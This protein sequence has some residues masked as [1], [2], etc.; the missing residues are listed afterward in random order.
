MDP[1]PQGGGRC[2]RHGEAGGDKGAGEERGREGGRA[3]GLATGGA[4]AGL[5]GERGEASRRCWWLARGMG[6]STTWGATPSRAWWPRA[7]QRPKGGK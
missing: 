5:T 7:G 1:L 4:Q 2:P 6:G 3:G